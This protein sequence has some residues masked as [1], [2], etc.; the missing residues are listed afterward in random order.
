MANRNCDQN[1]ETETRLVLLET[2]IKNKN[3]D[4]ELY[5]T[6]ICDY[7]RLKEDFMNSQH[8]LIALQTKFDKVTAENKRLKRQINALNSSN[9]EDKQS[10]SKTKYLR[11][12]DKASQTSTEDFNGTNHNVYRSSYGNETCDNNVNGYSTKQQDHHVKENNAASELVKEVTAAA[13]EVAREQFLASM[14][15]EETSGLYYDY[16]TGYYFDAERSLYYD[17]NR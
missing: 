2:L 4:I 17:G 14:A 9:S 12:S 6:K 8:K 11:Q 16:K 15:Y 3:K 5:Q 1:E 7:K 13:S 10:Y